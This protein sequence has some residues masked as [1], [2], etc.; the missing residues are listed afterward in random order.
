[1]DLDRDGRL[2]VI[3]GS[4]PGELYVFRGQA[5]GTYAK[6]EPITDADGDAINL[7]AAAAVYASDWDR[8][9]DLDLVVGDIEGAV[10]FVPNGS[11]GAALELGKASRLEADGE[12]ISVNHGDAGPIVV[13]WDAD[14]TLDLIVGTGSGDVLFF[15]NRAKEGAPKLAESVTLWAGGDKGMQLKP[16][17]AVRIGARVKPC[18]H[19]LDGDGRLDLLV[20][21]VI[22]VP[23]QREPLGPE[24]AARLARLQK[25]RDL[26]MQRY[27]PAMERVQRK[28]FEAIGLDPEET[29]IGELWDELDE[30]QMERFFQ[31]MEEATKK[32]IEA[33]ALE[34]MVQKVFEALHELE[35]RSNIHGHVWL[36]KR[37][38]A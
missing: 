18:V 13:D 3:S 7:G 38:P 15:A 37:R 28:A 25:K 19:D 35:P 11:G 4:Y 23:E 29:D 20:G 17:T 30:K 22:L 8:D 5:D 9:G 2:D 26:L 12:G 33:A 10:W 24:D 6:A 27:G 36:L 1:M 34:R 31:A 32:D 21:D 14:G 16:G